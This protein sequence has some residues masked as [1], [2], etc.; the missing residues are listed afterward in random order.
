MAKHRS[1]VSSKEARLRGWRRIPHKGAG[2]ELIDSIPISLCWAKRRVSGVTFGT[3]AYIRNN[4]TGEETTC[5]IGKPDRTV[6]TQYNKFKIASAVMYRFGSLQPNS[7]PAEAEIVFSANVSAEL[8]EALKLIVTAKA[9]FKD[10]DVSQV[11][12]LVSKVGLQEFKAEFAKMALARAI[13]E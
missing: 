10:S 7:L 8:Y 5:S 13:E 9:F 12:S 1:H 2:K 6:H 3:H 4:A 11:H